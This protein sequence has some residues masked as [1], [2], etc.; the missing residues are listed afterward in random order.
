MNAIDSGCNSV[1]SVNSTQI[2]IN[3][4]QSAEEVDPAIL[5]EKP[6]LQFYLTIGLFSYE[7]QELFTPNTYNNFLGEVSLTNTL[8]R[9]LEAYEKFTFI[10]FPI[11]R[12]VP[13]TDVSAAALINGI[14]YEA[15]PSPLISQSQ[16]LPEDQFCNIDNLPPG[17]NG[18]CSCTHMINIPLNSV[19]E[20]IMID[21]CK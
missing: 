8:K 19:V 1:N 18:T 9:L 11:C 13:A 15:P 3:N 16:D 12:T 5:K 4:L 10:L 2:C 21:S 7:L 14:S 6:D 20:I 17:C